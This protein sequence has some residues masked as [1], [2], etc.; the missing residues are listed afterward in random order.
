M[1]FHSQVSKV[2]G[3][4]SK[5]PEASRHGTQCVSPTKAGEQLSR[6][7]VRTTSS[8]GPAG[9]YQVFQCGGV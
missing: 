5:Q 4:E 6:V 9:L 1:G 7:D 3:T 8:A 2:T